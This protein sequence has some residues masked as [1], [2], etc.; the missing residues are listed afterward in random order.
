MSSPSST[1]QWILQ[2][3][4]VDLPILEGPDATFK[5]IHKNLPALQDGQVK[6]KS[7]YLSNDPAQRG[8]IQKGVLADR[9]YVPPVEEGAPMRAGGIGEVIE[10]RASSLPKGTLVFASVSW[11]EYA[12]LNAADCSALQNVPGVPVTAFLGSLGSSGLTAYYGLIDI[13][14]TSKTDVVVVSG[15]AGA[16]G[17]MVVQIAKHMVGCKRVIG[18]AGSDDKCRWAKSLGADEC[19]NYKSNSFTQDLIKATHGYADVYF[20][21]VGGDILDLVLTRMKRFGRI[22]ACGAIAS[23]NDSQPRGLRNW[24]EVVSNRLEIKGFIVLDVMSKFPEMRG[25]LVEA[26]AQGKI[27]VAEEHETLVKTPFEAIPKTWMMLF[28]GANT[29]KLVTKIEA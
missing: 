9:L 22:A 26:L 15:A 27:K 13:A 23:Y 14:K 1:R 5:L 21:N 16:V 28:E 19:L 17:S 12:V 20:D 18:I 24:F 10:T 25:K 3:Q 4:A 29:G 2:N 7:L 8:W 11:S 6:L